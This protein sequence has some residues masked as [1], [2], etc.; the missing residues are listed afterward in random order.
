[1]PILGSKVDEQKL[2]GIESTIVK[3]YEEDY[4]N[5][6]RITILRAGAI[7]LNEITKAIDEMH[8][9][10]SYEINE[11]SNEV[12]GDTSIAPGQELTHYSPNNAETYQGTTI[13]TDSILSHTSI[14]YSNSILI[15]TNENVRKYGRKYHKC[16]TLPDNA[17]GCASVLYSIMRNADAYC[18]ENEQSTMTIIICTEGI[19]AEEGCGYMMA[20]KDKVFRASS[21][22]EPVS[23]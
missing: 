5:I 1:M 2:V 21:G 20:I 16:F 15:A 11:H 19:R 9:D 23:I 13:A 18:K 6:V 8:I 17:K 14:G 12:N 10:V 4:T 3:I 22:K 7:G